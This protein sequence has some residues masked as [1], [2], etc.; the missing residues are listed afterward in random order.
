M[1]TDLSLG[2]QQE[3]HDTHASWL[4]RASLF[5]VFTSQRDNCD[6]PDILILSHCARGLCLHA[7][8][9]VSYEM[10]SLISFLLYYCHDINSRS[11]CMR[12]Y[13]HDRT[14]LYTLNIHNIFICDSFI[15]Y[16]FNPFIMQE[17]CI[18]VARVFTL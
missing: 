6:F 17:S 18:C 16:S 15:H 14:I 12:V 2:V 5:R 7:P 9:N 13:V 10:L 4:P 8:S 3:Q 11:Y 1:Q